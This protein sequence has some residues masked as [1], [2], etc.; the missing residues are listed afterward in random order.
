M[1]A[2]ISGM[3]AVS[4]LSGGAAVVVVRSA[5]DENTDTA[6]RVTAHV[7]LNPNLHLVLSIFNTTLDEY[8]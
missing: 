5:H 4:T 3:E 2:C 1:A 7:A 8:Q 6:A